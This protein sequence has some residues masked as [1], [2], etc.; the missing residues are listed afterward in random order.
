MFSEIFTW[1]EAQAYCE[2]IGGH[3]AT[4]TTAEENTAVFNFL[5]RPYETYFGLSDAEEEGVWKWVTG[6]S[7]EFANWE[8]GLPDNFNGKD[9]YAQFWETPEKWNDNTG[10]N[11]DT[12]GTYAISFVCEWDKLI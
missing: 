2:S 5:T 11:A 6:E 7:F 12:F 1:E 8:Y 4:L 3:L 9:H 10:S